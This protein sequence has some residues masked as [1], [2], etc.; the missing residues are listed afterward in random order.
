MARGDGDFAMGT[1][2]T[3]IEEGRAS[4]DDELEAARRAL[5]A[6]VPWLAR[7]LAR[8]AVFLAPASGA[9]AALLG[10]A[11]EAVGLRN[12]ARSGRA[13]DAVPTT[14]A[15]DDAVALEIDVALRAGRLSQR[16]AHQVE[17]GVGAGAGRGLLATAIGGGRLVHATAGG[18]LRALD[19]R[20][21][22][23]LATFGRRARRPARALAIRGDEVAEI[24]NDGRLTIWS[25]ADDGATAVRQ[26]EGS[27][28]AVVASA[29][30]FFVAG[31]GLAI[32]RGTAA[33]I[34]RVE[35]IA[36]IDSFIVRTLGVFRDGT[37]LVASSESAW[38]IDPVSGRSTPIELSPFPA[39]IA[40][41]GD[42]VIAATAD[43]FV[44]L[45][46][47]GRRTG[48]GVVPDRAP[49]V[50]VAAAA[51]GSTVYLQTIDAIYA[52][53]PA[54]G[55]VRWVEHVE[56]SGD[57]VV[58][59]GLVVARAGTGGFPSGGDG[60][61]DRTL[62][63]LRTSTSIRE[64]F[65]APERARIVAIS[66]AAAAEGRVGVI[67]ALVDPMRAWLSAEEAEAIELAFATAES[68][69]ARVAPAPPVPHEGEAGMNSPDPAPDPTP[70]PLPVP[71]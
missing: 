25:L 4:A 60:R 61:D 37:L 38:R 9:A 29:D 68:N 65:G 55:R 30:A 26:L 27:A 18:R 13:G 69:R 5:D 51:D 45:D 15:A 41:A 16:I 42:E 63:V 3:R 56:G 48:G 35:T 14:A 20:T 44:R 53:D 46:R 1:F 23:E 28:E 22:R 58:G 11:S 12:P 7:L 71:K 54:D 59:E 49:I 24:A 36:P 64:P 67:R 8:R 43:S 19:A 47:Q 62:Y 32:H 6:D 39:A 52:V 2:L 31:F 21:G 57:P 66:T 70:A 34:A 50:G 40:V 10:K 17:V 33:G